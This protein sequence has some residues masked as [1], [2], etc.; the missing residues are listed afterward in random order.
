VT[1]SPTWE[2]EATLWAGGARLV[3]GC[4]EAGRGPLAGPVVAA[5]VLLPPQTLLPGLTDSKLLDAPTRDRLFDA[6]HDVALA[7]GVGLCEADE[8]DRL[9][10]LRASL[11]A[12]RRAVEALT[13]APDGLL[14]DGRQTVPGLRLAQQAL[15]KGD[16]RSVSVAAASIVAKVSRDRLMVAHDARWPGYGFAGH[17]GYP[18]PSHLA[19]LR[20]L[21]PCPLHRRSYGPVRALLADPPP[22]PPAR[23]RGASVAQLALF[24]DDDERA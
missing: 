1:D 17:K 6:V 7:V 11:L 23:S 16:R 15:V 12:M 14:V 2:C 20:A 19:A 22:L 4:D 9:N 5:A 10:I 3:A 8:I 21:G 24:G 13:P 18:A